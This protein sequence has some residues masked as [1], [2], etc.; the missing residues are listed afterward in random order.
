VCG[1][2][3]VRDEVMTSPWVCLA[4]QSRREESEGGRG[5]E[6]QGGLGVVILFFL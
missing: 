1:G 3:S 6:E 5:E 2:K 4:W